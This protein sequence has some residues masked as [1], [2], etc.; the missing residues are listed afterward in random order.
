MG[1]CT[2]AHIPDRL[3][4]TE[5]K[6][7]I[8]TFCIDDLLYRRIKENILENPYANISLT[9]LSH[10]IGM[11]GS[12]EIS[13]KSDVLFSIVADNEIEVYEDEVLALKII[14]LN[15]DALY[16]KL[17]ACL[18]NTDLTARIVLSHDPVCCMYPH[19]VF[20]FFVSDN[21]D[22]EEEVTF[23]NYRNTLGHKRFKHLRE[24]LRHEISLMIVREE[25]SYENFQ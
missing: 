21:Q 13:K 24:Q 20:K 8:N 9:D 25:I 12:M 15:Q 23:A 10:N 6:Q 2:L 19:C 18:K 14:S 16:N 3:H 11:N 1:R 5:E 7:L 22:M 17:F 4:N